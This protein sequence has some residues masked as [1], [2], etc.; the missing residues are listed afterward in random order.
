[1][2]VA[3]KASFV[4]RVLVRIFGLLRLV[5]LSYITQVL[6]Q[7]L[8]KGEK[9]CFRNLNFYFR[10]G[11]STSTARQKSKDLNKDQNIYQE[12]VSY[13]DNTSNWTSY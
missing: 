8:V 7:G 2:T 11:E 3:A 6:G 1:M 5:D 9:F 4:I 13:L 12:K 10:H